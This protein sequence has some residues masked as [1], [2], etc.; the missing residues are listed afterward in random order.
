MTILQLEKLY[1]KSAESKA[2]IAEL[3]KGPLSYLILLHYQS[4][5]QPSFPEIHDFPFY[6]FYGVTTDARTDRHCP[7]TGLDWWDVHFEIKLPFLPE[8]PNVKKARMYKVLPEIVEDNTKG[9]ETCSSA[10]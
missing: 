10:T 8:A 2:F 9:T 7:P 4:L 6:S 3:T 5:V 1:G